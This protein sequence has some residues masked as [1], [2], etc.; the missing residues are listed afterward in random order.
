MEAKIHAQDICIM[1]G[2]VILC[3]FPADGGIG[4]LL[5]V[6]LTSSTSIEPIASMMKTGTVQTVCRSCEVHGWHGMCFGNVW[7][8]LPLALSALM[9]LVINVTV[10]TTDIS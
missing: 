2:C 4:T 1:E 5:A 6:N 8:H 3:P 7:F 10:S 9:L